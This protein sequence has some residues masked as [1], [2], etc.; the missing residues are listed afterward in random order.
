MC[1]YPWNRGKKATSA[2]CHLTLQKGRA[3]G[4]C[5]FTRETRGKGIFAKTVLLPFCG[6]SKLDNF[7]PMFCNVLFSRTLQCELASKDHFCEETESFP[8]KSSA[9][10]SRK[11]SPRQELKSAFA[12]QPKGLHDLLF[13][14]NDRNTHHEAQN[15]MCCRFS[16]IQGSDLPTYS[17]EIIS[18]FAS[19]ANMGMETLQIYGEEF[20]PLRGASLR[21][22]RKQVS[23]LEGI[24]KEVPSWCSRLGALLWPLQPSVERLWR[25]KPHTRTHS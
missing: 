1:L 20:V 3:R 4:G 11:S 18:D 21:C 8:D 19:L 10:T 17:S 15:H 12:W 9:F 13:A 25:K 24:W 22:F 14:T 7:G 5:T 6:T 2:A 23:R 16:S